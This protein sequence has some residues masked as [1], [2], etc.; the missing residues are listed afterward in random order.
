V[1]I[2]K[3][4]LDVIFERFSQADNKSDDTLYTGTGIGLSLSKEY[5][6]MHHGRIWAENG[7]DGK[8]S[9]FVVEIPVGKGHF[10]AAETVTYVDDNTAATKQ[11]RTPVSPQETEE[12]HDE[13]LPVLILVEDNADLCRMLRLQLKSMYNV[14]VANDGNDGLQKIF[15]Y[16]PDIIVTD[17]MMP[18][19]DGLELLKRVRKDFSV[20]HIPVIVL[21]AKTGEDEMMNAITAGANAYITKPFNSE[22]LIARINQLL[23]EQ[24]V[25]Q[26]KMLL[27]GGVDTADKGNQDTYEQ[28][29][30]K[31]DLEFVRKIHEVIESNINAADFN[32]DT[33]AESIG[34][35]RSSFFKKLKSLTGFAPVDLVKEVR[36]AKAAKLIETTDDSITEIAYSVGFRDSGYFGKCFRKKYGMTPKEYRNDK[37]AK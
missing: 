1:G 13:T 4:Q 23:E 36:L 34:L 35:S 2:P 27:Q 9:T 21:T 12:Q 25:F 10:S 19:I 11:E 16:H 30:V 3:S 17:L 18:G 20:S 28:H 6:N 33:I 15:Q 32:I 22:H 37:R 24:R 5:I 26:R 31:K 29:L 7:K 14:Y 8:G